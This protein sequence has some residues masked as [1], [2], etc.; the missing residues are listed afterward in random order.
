V[1]LEEYIFYVLQ[2]LMSGLFTLWLLTRRPRG[3]DAGADT[4]A[5]REREA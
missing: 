1:P 2:V 3:G 4:P 5:E